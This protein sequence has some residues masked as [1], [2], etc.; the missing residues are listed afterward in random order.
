MVSLGLVKTA[1]ECYLRIQKWEDVITCYTLIDLKHKAAEIIRQEIKKKPTVELYC[2]LGDATD[3]PAFYEQA[4]NMSNEKSGRAQRHWGGFYYLRKDYKNCIPHL[5]KSLELNNLQEY[6]WA[7]LGYAALTL[8]DWELA[9]RAYRMYTN[10]EPNGFEAWNNLAKAYI[11]LG[12][13]KRA[14]KVL[15]EAIKCNFNNWKVWE[16]FLIVSTATFNYEDVLNAYNQLIE[17]KGK[18][19]DGQIL[20]TTVVSIANNRPDADDKPSLR[21]AK[22]AQTLLGRL[23]VQLPSEGKL[24]EFAAMLCADEPLAKA[25][26][27]Q[28]AFRCYT[29]VDF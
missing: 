10:I 28:R 7:R 1:L 16:N 2:M 14:H 21:L 4:W 15:Q 12:D 27:L 6:V 19:Y 13:L 26:K 3:D 24:W 29:Q 11:K 22:K 5:Q 23:C 8:E 17:L 18:Y 20:E 25:Q 9:A